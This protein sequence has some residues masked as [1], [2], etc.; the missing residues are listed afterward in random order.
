MVCSDTRV[1]IIMKVDE[2][3]PN[4]NDRLKRIEINK[5]KIS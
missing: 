3:K 1:F 5:Q 4:N 2:L